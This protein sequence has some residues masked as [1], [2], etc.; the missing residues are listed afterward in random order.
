MKGITSALALALIANPL[1]ACEFM[2]ETDLRI[3]VSP[4]AKGLSEA[5][6]HALIDR[7]ENHYGPLIAAKGVRLIVERKWDSDRVNAGTYRS[8]DGKDWH[9]NLYGGFARHPYITEDGYLLVMC[10]ELGHHLGGAPKKLETRTAQWS[11]AEG[12]ADYFATLKCLRSL[13]ENDDNRSIVS[14][15]NVPPI[16]REKCAAFAKA[17]ERAL[18]ERISLAGHSVSLVSADSQRKPAPEFD[19]PDTSVV[20]ETYVKHPKAQ[21]RLDTYFQGSLCPVPNSVHVSQKDEV[22]GTCHPSL[23]HV[24]G[25]RP[26]CW[27]KPK[28]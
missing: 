2:P 12:Q 15:M 28:Q 4:H 21:C 8:Q 14:S 3:P 18:C 1:L 17:S 11:S 23:G 7:V 9:V 10:H 20:D 24:E 22:R 25:N 5:R 16:V 6:Y 27:F 19:Q 13:F 26:L